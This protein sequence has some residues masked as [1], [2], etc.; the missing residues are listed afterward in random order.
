ML[1]QYLIV[2]NEQVQILK[3]KLEKET[4][5]GKMFDLWPYMVNANVDIITGNL[6]YMGNSPKS[7]I[8]Q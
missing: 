2:F 6:R 5:S 3:L 1:Q 4:N 7:A 8:S